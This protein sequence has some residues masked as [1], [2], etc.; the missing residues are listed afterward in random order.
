MINLDLELLLKTKK[1][2]LFVIVIVIDV[3]NA[4]EDILLWKAVNMKE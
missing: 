2:K 1:D 4:Q 3:C